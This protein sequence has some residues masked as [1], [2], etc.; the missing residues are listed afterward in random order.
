MSILAY[1][2]C[3]LVIYS[4]QFISLNLCE[5]KIVKRVMKRLAAH[6]KYKFISYSLQLKCIIEWQF[7]KFDFPYISDF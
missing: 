7:L 5:N 3:L 1:A 4:K 2:V 6:W